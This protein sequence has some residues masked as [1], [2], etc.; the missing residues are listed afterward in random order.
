[1]HDAGIDMVTN[2]KRQDRAN[3]GS[4]DNDEQM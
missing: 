2:E 1:M 4:L 3:N